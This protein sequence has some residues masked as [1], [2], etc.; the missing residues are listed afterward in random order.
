MSTKIK[1]IVQLKGM[2]KRWRNLSLC[3]NSNI[4]H[5]PSDSVPV[6]AGFI[7]I[8]V[9]LLLS[10]EPK[11][12]SDGVHQKRFVIPLRFLNY[13]VF[14]SLLMAT[15]EQIGFAPAG[16]L[17]IF[18]D[19]GFF[20]EMMGLLEKDEGRFKG[21]SLSEFESCI[22]ATYFNLGCNSSV[23]GSGCSPLL[24]KAVRA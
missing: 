15:E 2:M 13:P 9:G 24:K 7:A 20:K 5:S 21:Y 22:F 14:L 6:R 1:Q 23:G 4:L 11:T 3:S 12:S 8:D 10:E 19:V 17:A 18:C 16:V